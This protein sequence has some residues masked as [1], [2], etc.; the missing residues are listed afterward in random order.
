MTQGNDSAERE[1]R[2]EPD[3]D[4]TWHVTVKTTKKTIERPQLSPS[5]TFFGW[6]IDHLSYTTDLV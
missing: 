1:M 2:A 4:C 5:A 6:V 3:A